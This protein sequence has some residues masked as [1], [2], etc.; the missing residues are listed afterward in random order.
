MSADKTRKRRG[1]PLLFLI[2]VVAGWIAARTATF[3]PL[4]Q[5]DPEVPFQVAS[6]HFSAPPSPSREIGASDV[7]AAAAVARMNPKKTADSA[8]VAGENRPQTVSASHNAVKRS[9]VSNALPLSAPRLAQGTPAT[10]QSAEFGTPEGTAAFPANLTA[11]AA[12]RTRWSANG[13]LLLRD[14]ATTPILSGRPSY[15][16]SQAGAV[17][18][19]NLAPASPL[20]PQAYVRASAALAGPREQE[21]AAGVSARP[22]AGVPLR[23]AVEARAGETARGTRLRPAAFAV[24]EFPPLR[25]PL[26]ARAEVYAQAGYVG[27]EYATAFADGQARIE[28]PLVQRGQAEL[29]AGGG[30]WGGAQRGAAR[31]DIGPTA[32]VTFRV[33]EARGRVA[34]DYRFRVAG[35]AE[36]SSGP[37]LT[38]SAGF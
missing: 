2:A 37:A 13:W 16:R 5:D 11:P 7:L 23:L 14:D 32:A 22:I 33:G 29:A 8:M 6:P 35:D 21:V 27:G 1:D 30:V 18:R 3:S 36:P 12:T 9:S 24:T 4:W 20:R 34:A 31:L 38:V 25:L 28:R 26:G 10:L 19:Y 17:I 15:G